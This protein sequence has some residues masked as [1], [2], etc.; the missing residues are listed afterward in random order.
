MTW[1]KMLKK[2]AAK[3]RCVRS[4]IAVL[5]P[6]E[7]SKFQWPRPRNGFERP[8]RPSEASSTGLKSFDTANGS[9]NRFKP[10]PF[11]AGSLLVPTP[12]DP[13]DPVC[14]PS[15]NLSGLTVGTFPVLNPRASVPP[16]TWEPSVAVSGCPLMAV[17][18]PELYQPSTIRL[19]NECELLNGRS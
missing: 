19:R 16:H 3:L 4:V 8:E 12:L 2:S 18:M 13:V 10:E 9:P 5:F 14:T 1:L 15:P 7:A 11:F 17:K 6:T